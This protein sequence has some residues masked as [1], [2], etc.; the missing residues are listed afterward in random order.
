MT[1]RKPRGYDP[2]AFPPFAVTVDIVVFTLV[3]FVMKTLLIRRGGSPHKGAWA[4][5][6]GFKTPS[7]SL[8][9][10]AKR[11]LVEE[12]GVTPTS[13]LRQL[14]AYGD[15]GRD[16]RMN[17]V[18]VAFVT[19][20]RTVDVIKSGSDAADAALY[21]VADI[22]S[23]SLPTAF[24]H[25][26]IVTDALEFLRREIEIGDLITAFVGTPF[27]LSALRAAYES[28]WGVKMDPANFRRKLVGKAG[29]LVP[30]GRFGAPGLA[31]GKPAELYRLGRAWRAGGPLLR[32]SRA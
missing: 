16:P 21:P 18:T 4:L 23:G 32:R 2:S 10:A 6:G 30:T 29:W 1:N 27:T 14:G 31:G 24:D 5:P 13:E 25:R 12:T 15:P 28:V 26:R 7:E 9:T 22:V 20:M 19:V 8:E 3:E 11:E 17:V